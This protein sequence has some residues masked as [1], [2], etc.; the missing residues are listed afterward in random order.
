MIR[1]HSCYSESGILRKAFRYAQVAPLLG[2]YIVENTQVL[3][4]GVLSR[5]NNPG[6]A[7]ALCE[8]A[9]LMII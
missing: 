3:R 4:H 6:Y 8:F 7:L 9:T 1:P 2:C 5:L